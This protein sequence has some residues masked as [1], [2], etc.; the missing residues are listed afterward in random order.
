MKT[1]KSSVSDSSSTYPLSSGPS[2]AISSYAPNTSAYQNPPPPRPSYPPTSQPLHSGSEIQREG[3]PTGPSL[4]NSGYS[5]QNPPYHYH[6]QGITRTQVPPMQG[7]AGYPSTSSHYGPPPS[8]SADPTNTGS[9]YIRPGSRGTNDRESGSNEPFSSDISANSSNNNRD[10]PQSYRPSGPNIPP[11]MSQSPSQPVPVPPYNRGKHIPPQPPSSS[12]QPTTTQG[13]YS[14]PNSREQIESTTMFPPS[15]SN[16]PP[17][18]TSPIRPSYMPSRHESPQSSAYQMPPISSAPPNSGYTPQ[19]PAPHPNSSYYYNQQSPQHPS[20]SSMMMN[21]PRPPPGYMTNNGYPPTGSPFPQGAVPGQAPTNIPSGASVPG[22]QHQP[23]SRD[24]MQF[25]G[26]PPQNG[27]SGTEY[28]P[29]YHNSMNRMPGPGR[30]GEMNRMYPPGQMAGVPNMPPKTHS[31]HLARL[32]CSSPSLPGSPTPNNLP[33]SL[34]P[35]MT[36][37]QH[38]GTNF[39]PQPQVMK[40]E[41]AF[42]P[43]TVEASQPL[44]IKHRKLSPKDLPQVDPWRLMMSLKSGLL[45]ETTWALDILTVLVSHDNTYLFFGLPHLPGLLDTLL[46]HYKKCLNEIFEDIVKDSELGVGRSIKNLEQNRK[47]KWYEVCS[48][49]DGCDLEPEVKRLNG[50]SD[51]KEEEKEEEKEGGEEEDGLMDWDEVSCKMEMFKDIPKND[52]YLRMLRSSMNYTLKSR[53]G[54]SVKF[55]ETETLFSTDFDKKWDR[56]HAGFKVEREHWRKGFSE[57]TDHILTHFEPKEKPIKLVKLIKHRRRKASDP[58]SKCDEKPAVSPHPSD[59]KDENLLRSQELAESIKHE[60]SKN[61]AVNCIHKTS[62]ASF[63]KDKGLSRRKVNDKSSHGISDKPR[64]TSPTLAMNE[65]ATHEKPHDFSSSSSSSSSP[66]NMSKSMNHS[67][68]SNNKVE[69]ACVS[70]PG[71]NKKKRV[72]TDPANFDELE[73]EVDSEIGSPL[74]PVYDYCDSLARRCLCI[75][76]LIRNLSFVPMNDVEMSK[77]AGLLLVLGRLLKIGHTHNLKKRSFEKPDKA[78]ENEQPQV[79]R[80]SYLIL[81][82]FKHSNFLVFSR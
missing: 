26:Y 32:L 76:T 12:G 73:E 35:Q 79:N 77:H 17:S 62:T 57:S 3:Y 20:Q 6:Q 42:P 4:S 40:K 43:G 70:Q 33:P 10:H 27:P 14:M 74:H 22:G 81:C 69:A 48:Y 80:Y 66:S 18:S 71:T 63:N 68:S 49:D 60:N 55:E 46:E 38:S 58:V 45:A 72:I 34:T 15:S 82:V 61:F 31:A 78:M 39:G 53:V 25:R 29:M 30:A 37:S 54:K 67:N 23:W 21:R 13:T 44:L 50:A 28:P 19:R 11:H 47:K 36:A 9:S 64:Q 52:Q 65:D 56:L 41:M 5:Q 8:A 7:N 1:S 2:D 59:C 51:V 24:G 16:Q 75:S